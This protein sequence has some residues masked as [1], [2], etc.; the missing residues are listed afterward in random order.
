MGFMPGQFEV[1]EKVRVRDDT[2]HRDYLTFA[3]MTGT[4]VGRSK[5]MRTWSASDVSYD[6][7]YRVRFDVPTDPNLNNDQRKKLARLASKTLIP[8]RYLEAAVSTLFIR[9]VEGRW[10]DVDS[11][12]DGDRI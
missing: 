3:G 5:T 6:Y 1:D 2:R 8:G 11:V 12:S 7:S 9:K 4:V 10:R